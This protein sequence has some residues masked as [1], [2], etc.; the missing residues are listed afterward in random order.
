MA[1]F[2]SDNAS[3]ICPEIMTALQAAN[4]GDAMAYGNDAI[5]ARAEHAIADL[6]ET[7]CRVFPVATGTIA[8][9]LALTAISK[10]YG[11][12]F[13]HENSHIDVDECGGPEFFSGGA[14]LRPLAGDKAKFSADTLDR[15]IANSGI[16]GVHH[17]QATGVSLTQAT[18]LGTVYSLDEV[19]AIGEVA[20][21]YDLHYHMDGARFANAVATLGCSAAEATWKQGVDVMSFGA[22]K[23]GAL[24]AEA[25]IFF[26]QALADGFEYHRKRA[27][28]LF[29]K[30]RF[31]SA[32]LEAYVADDL[33][34]RN[35]GHA[36][37]Q[38]QVLA[39]ALRSATAGELYA[40]V[41]GNQVFITLPALTIEAL[42]QA[43]VQCHRWEGDTVRFVTSFNT[44]DDAIDQVI[45]IAGRDAA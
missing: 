3:G 2:S 9:C 37:D 17:S 27:G 10:P 28:Q 29:S 20:H 35:A 1:K 12:I 14:K 44:S 33:W 15:A 18:E 22:T 31:V 5:T 19:R 38:A 40:P 4:E 16:G 45:K 26:N 32:Q 7:N 13:C 42:H 39:A 43:G 34:L 23:N 41:E 30:M 21:K 11:A 6:F 24:A 25:V 8:N 36:N